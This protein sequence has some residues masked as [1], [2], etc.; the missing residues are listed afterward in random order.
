MAS[1]DVASNICQALPSSATTFSTAAHS[2]FAFAF[3]ATCAM[4]VA[5]ADTRAENVAFAADTIANTSAD[6]PHHTR[7]AQH[8]RNIARALADARTR[9]VTPA[10]PSAAQ[11]VP[12]AATALG[13]TFP[14]RAP[15]RKDGGSRR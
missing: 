8:V 6:I 1:Y 5:T 7:R 14:T 2:S 10:P 4:S 11:T 15:T 12:R 3:A 13:F 9:M